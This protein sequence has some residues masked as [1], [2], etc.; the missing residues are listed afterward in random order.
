[1]LFSSFHGLRAVAVLLFSSLRRKGRRLYVGYV[2]QRIFIFNISSFTVLMNFLEKCSF[3]GFTKDRPSLDWQYRWQFA[4]GN[5]QFDRRTDEQTDWLTDWLIDWLIDR[6][7]D[8]STNRFYRTIKQVNRSV[9]NHWHIPGHWKL[10]FANV[11]IPSAPL[12]K[13]NGLNIPTLTSLV[14][15]NQN[16]LFKLETYS[17]QPAI[18]TFPVSF[19][20]R[21]S[22]VP[23]G[24]L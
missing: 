11:D 4:G 5:C 16:H 7:I 12:L 8:R 17:V 22:K 2:F 13:N 24:K 19:L 3:G 23:D 15:E 9:Y 10:L 20:I 1:M 18:N 6:S 14:P 21:K